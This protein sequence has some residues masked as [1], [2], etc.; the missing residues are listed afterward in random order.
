MDKVIRGEVEDE[1]APGS[2]AKTETQEKEQVPEKEV[3]RGLEPP[4]PEFI[5]DVPS[6]S[7]VDM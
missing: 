4:V 6:I 7:A 3:D 1:P 2:G 5:L